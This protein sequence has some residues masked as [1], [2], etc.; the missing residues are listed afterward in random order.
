M[1]DTQKKRNIRIPLSKISNTAFANIRNEEYRTEAEKRKQEK[2]RKALKQSILLKG[3]L[4]PIL[5]KRLA[6][7]ERERFVE[8]AGESHG[9]VYGVVDGHIRYDVIREI[10]EEQETPRPTILAS[11]LDPD[12]ASPAGLREI[13]MIGNFSSVN[14]TQ[15]EKA[16]LVYPALYDLDE[17]GIAKVVDDTDKKGNPRQDRNG[18]TKKV[19][20][21]KEVSLSAFAKKLGVTHAYIKKLCNIYERK[22]GIPSALTPT[23]T[24]NGRESQTERMNR[25]GMEYAGESGKKNILDKLH[26]ASGIIEATQGNGNIESAR[27]QLKQIED[28]ISY[29]KMK[30]EQTESNGD[31]GNN[32]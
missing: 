25:W 12:D 6:D 14:M 17:N 2:E 28:A 8:E 9:Y 5:V 3:Q 13:M 31:K 1:S 26:L 20:K 24:R 15:E 21:C 11:E 29:L 19:R 7:D 4:V 27:E 30:L 32:I 16:E 18:N 10:A 23:V 22:H